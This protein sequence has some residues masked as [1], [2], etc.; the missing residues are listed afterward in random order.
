MQGQ[1][2]LTAHEAE[3]AVELRWRQVEAIAEDSAAVGQQFALRR[4][5][6][7]L[8]APHRHPV[9]GGN[10]RRR[11]PLD[12]MKPKNI[13][14][15]GIEQRERRFDRSLEL[16]T[17]PLFHGTRVSQCR[18]L[19]VKGLAMKP[20]LRTANRSPHLGQRKRRGRPNRSRRAR[21]PPRL[22]GPTPIRS[23]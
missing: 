23:R 1:A 11:K 2:E 13:A 14:R 4:G 12:E 15:A 16:R 17:V 20:W 18:H 5:D 21:C 19:S 8:Y 22:P 3:Q 7:T 9:H 6:P 10:R